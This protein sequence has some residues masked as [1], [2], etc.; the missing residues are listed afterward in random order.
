[1]KR[2][3]TL[4]ELMATVGLIGLL[5]LIMIPGIQ[6]LRNAA[7]LG[8]C[9]HNL[10]MLVTANTLYAADHGHYVAAAP[11]IMG[12]NLTRWHGARSATSEPFDGTGGPLSPYLGYDRMVRRCGA[13]RAPPAGTSNTFEASCGGYGYN[14]RGVGSQMYRR[15]YTAAAM[16]KGIPPAHL[17]NPAGTIMFADAAFPQPYGS[18]T[19][20][21]E[22]S[23]AEAYHFVTRSGDGQVREVG[24]AMPSI[25]FRHNGLANVAW[26]D[27]HVSAAPLSTEYS[28]AFTDMQVGWPGDGNNDLFRPF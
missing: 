14:D 23:F 7:A 10:K 25:H 22:Y 15:G 5:T 21:I 16:K 8:Q 28:Q 1:M 9:A 26:C 20:V 2:G 12:A 27:G 18:P 3:F 17:A 24:T 4:I 19:H 11:D 13:F 6:R